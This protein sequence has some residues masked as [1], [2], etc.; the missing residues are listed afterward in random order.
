LGAGDYED[1]YEDD[2]HQS[3]KM[4]QAVSNV[5][6]NNES[7]PGSSISY[8]KDELVEEDTKGSSPKRAPEANQMDSIS[9]KNR[10]GE[11]AQSATSI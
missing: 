7:K 9:P 3:I 4:E 2:F 10:S 6:A 8:P 5:P 1:D 11:G